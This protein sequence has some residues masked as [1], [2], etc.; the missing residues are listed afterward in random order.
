MATPG[1]G[2]STVPVLTG[3]YLVA[4]G[5]DLT[6][7]MAAGTGPPVMSGT[8]VPI[9]RGAPSAPMPPAGP[10]APVPRPDGQVA[11]GAAPLCFTLLAGPPLVHA[12]RGT[13]HLL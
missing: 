5:R 3:I 4:A 11:P 9:Q 10:P 8:A 1:G 7:P 12:A 2:A 6:A 13:L